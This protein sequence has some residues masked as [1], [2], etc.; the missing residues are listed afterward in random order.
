LSA[1]TLFLLLVSNLQSSPLHPLAHH[2]RVA[3]VRWKLT[4]GFRTQT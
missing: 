3:G 2:S 1:D 4:L